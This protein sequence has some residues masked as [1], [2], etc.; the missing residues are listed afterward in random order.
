MVKAS[1]RWITF[2]AHDQNINARHF[3]PF[4]PQM[5][6]SEC[7]WLLKW[8]WGEWWVPKSC[9]RLSEPRLL[10]LKSLEKDLRRSPNVF[11]ISNSTIWNIVHN[12]R[13]KHLPSH[14]GLDVQTSSPLEQITRW[15]KKSPNTLKC[16][17]VDPHSC[18][19]EHARL[20]HQ[21]EY[22]SLLHG[23]KQNCLEFSEKNHQR[24]SIVSW[25][26]DALLQQDLFSGRSLPLCIASPG[27]LTFGCTSSRNQ[28]CSYL[29]SFLLVSKF[30]DFSL[31]VVVLKKV[32]LF[33]GV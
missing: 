29:H 15:E 9:P 12:W 1:H 23:G 18:W 20:Y 17:T 5:F 10:S 14:A 24:W 8:G 31:F 26:G 28:L 33:P 16:L 21:I 7:P 32:C 22:T 4:K 19:C 6:R 3:A 13:R 2:C 27:F 11:N 30:S 25:F